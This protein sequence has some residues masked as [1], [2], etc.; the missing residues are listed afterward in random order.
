MSAS[1]DS[2]PDSLGPDRLLLI[3]VGAHLQAEQDHRPLRIN[4]DFRVHGIDECC[5]D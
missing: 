4:R 1:P 3:V 5:Q 2:D